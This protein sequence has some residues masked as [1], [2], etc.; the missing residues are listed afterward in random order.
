M[1]LTYKYRL[2]PTNKQRHALDEILFQMQ[3]VYNDALNERRWYWQRS[4]QSISY[5]DQWKRMKEERQQYPDEMGLLNATSVQQMLR[6]LDK[7]YKAFYQGLRGLP[8]FKG[9]NRFKSVEYRHG[10]GSK[11]KGDR[12]Y[13][14]HVG[15]IKIRLHRPI[16]DQATIKHVVIKLTGGNWDVALM[17]E[18]PA[19]EPQFNPGPAVGIDVGLKSLLALSDGTLIDNPR[20]LRVS[21][22]K[23]RVEQRKMARHKR[24]SRGWYAAKKQ[25]ARLHEKIAN[26]RKDFWHK[27]TTDLANTYGA[28]VI[29]DLP[30]A[31]MLRNKNLSLSAHDAALGMFRPMLTY[32]VEKT[33][34]LLLAENP[35]GTSQE[36][37]GCG[38]VVAKS[39]SIRTHVCPNCGLV[40]DRDVNAAVNLLKRAG[41]AREALTY[42]VADCVASEA[43]PL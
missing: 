11:L 24:F 4:R 21:L 42:P 28:I 25:V 39:L 38:S 40:L 43:P 36:C 14:Q 12:L 35:K 20:W 3:T 16:P 17:M 9:R 5:F 19:L 29:E 31:F 22:A 2:R 30:L 8:R 33:G 23:L 32:K 15:E 26:Q 37:S 13:I 34:T 27:L 41:L 10:D 1:V 7:S 6:R 18:V